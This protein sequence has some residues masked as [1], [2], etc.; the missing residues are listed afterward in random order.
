MTILDELREKA[1][2]KGRH[3]V[4]AEGTDPRTILAAGRIV[5]EGIA[6]I[7]LLGKPDAIRQAAKDAIADLSGLDIIDP[8]V[9]DW[10]DEFTAELTRLRAHKGMTPELA[11]EK[12]SDP[13]YF[14]TMMVHM[15]YADGML[16]G[17]VNTSASVL[18][19]CLEI[20]KTKPGIKTASGAFLI[21]SPLEELG[22][23]GRFVFADGAVNP[24]PNA[25]Q[26]AEIAYCSAQTA[27]HIAGIKEPRVAMLSFSTKGSSEHEQITVVR[28]ATRL[29]HERYPDLILDG[30]FQLD[31]AVVPSVCAAKAPDSP[32][33]GR[34][35]VLVFPD[36]QSGNICSKAV[37][38]FGSARA[39]GPVLQGMRKPVND[40]SR[41]CSTDDIVNM[42]SIVCCQK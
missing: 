12:I 30:E 33:G 11:R 42:V 9:S 28:E 27:I 6:K 20:I 13:L 41:G 25:E 22:D 29:A 16:A 21:V 19:P 7:T 14:S 31:A 10:Q 38:R 24:M 34:A 36:L 5:R 17:A 37:Q 2:S 18:R 3:I 1:Q 39:L 15:G 8:N 26:L 4:L 32:V 23:R 40:L 35:N